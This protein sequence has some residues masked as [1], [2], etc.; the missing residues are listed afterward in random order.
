MKVTAQMF[1]TLANGRRRVMGD[2]RVVHARKSLALEGAP[3]IGKTSV[4]RSLADD[5]GLPLVTVAINQWLN[6]ADIVGFA[7]KSRSTAGGFEISA[8]DDIPAWLPVYRLDPV[9]GTKVATSDATKGYRVYIDPKTNAAVPHAAVILLD[10]F[11]SA[12]PSVQQAFLTVALD[13]TVKNFRL[14]EDTNFFLAYNS[15]EREGF[16]GQTNEISAALVGPNGRFDPVELIYDSASVAE[17]VSKNPIIS[18]FWKKFTIKFLTELDIC[19]DNVANDKN[20]CGRTWESLLEELSICGFDSKN[21]NSDAKIRVEL[22]FATSPTV[23]KRFI[24]DVMNCDVPGGEDYLA[25][26]VSVKTFSDAIIGIHAMVT[27][28]GF[29]NRCGKAVIKP[30]ED[31][32]LKDFMAKPFPTGMKNSDGIGIIGSKK[33]LFMVLK[34]GLIRENLQSRPEFAWVPSVLNSFEEKEEDTDCEF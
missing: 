13:R 9:S 25:G 15:C 24:T 21:F 29:R 10:E 5:W 23:A 20:S 22:A 30:C 8:E 28:F 26:K 14:H 4:V 34:T 1:K 12:K 6:A 33:E 19:N 31:S 2:G 27:L 32:Y 7:Y 3:G 11:S 17:S 18:D 16:E